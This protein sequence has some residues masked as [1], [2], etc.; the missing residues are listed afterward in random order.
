[1]LEEVSCLAS[2]IDREN[3][4]RFSRLRIGMT[5]IELMVVVAI[6]AALAGIFAAVMVN[7]DSDNAY[8]EL[9]R[10]ITTLFE[11]QRMRAMSMS[12]PTYI[13]FY[14]SGDA[15]ESIEPRL[16]ANNGFTVCA[17]ED[18]SVRRQMIPLRYDDS[19]A[20]NVAIDIS[21]KDS[22]RTSEV[23]VSDKYNSGSKHYTSVSLVSTSASF[24]KVEHSLSG[25]NMIACFQPNGMVYFIHANNIDTNV[26][27]LELRIRANEEISHS[28]GEYR[29]TV[30]SLGMIGNDRV[31]DP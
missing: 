17:I 6:I 14:M 4:M 28:P 11:A 31:L 29:V 8:S 10:E 25:V 21:R 18:P 2:L 9:S 20:D 7:N 27:Q 5:L 30:N 19:N 12:V 22:F 16:G 15:V 3:K 13:I 1:M 26:E 23:R 24:P